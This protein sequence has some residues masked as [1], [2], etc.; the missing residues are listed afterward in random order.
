MQLTR[1][2]MLKLAATMAAGSI[3]AA[4]G[5]QTPAAPSADQPP[6]AGSAAP[7]AGAAPSAGQ[8]TAAAS[9]TA[10]AATG[11]PVKITL[12]ESWFAVPQFQESI[13]P[14][15]KALSEKMQKEGLNIELESLILDDHATKYPVLY[16]SGADF[17]MAFDAPWYKMDSLRS[18][19]ALAQLEGLIDQYGPKLKE[20]ITDKIYQ[21]NLIDGHQYGIPTVYYY[22]SSSGVMLREDLR[23]KYNAPAPTPDGGW[24]SLTPYL[25]AIKANEPGLIPFANIPS[26]SIPDIYSGHVMAPAKGM[27]IPDATKDLKLIDVEDWPEFIERAKLLRV[28]WEQDLINKTDLSLSGQSQ[29]VQADYIYPGKAAA[30]TENEPDYK[31]IDQSKQLKASIPDGA[32]MGY[33]MKGLRAGKRSFGAL[34]AGNFIVFNGNAPK[35]QHVAGIQFFNWLVGSQD[36]LDLWLMG[37]EGVNY[38]KEDNMRFSEIPGTDAARNYRRQWYVSGVSGRFQRQPVDLP[39]AAAEALTFFSTESNWDFNKYEAFQIDRKAVE[40]ELAKLEAVYTEA[41]HGIY[42]GQVATDE[43][44]Q[45]A[46]QLLDD[47]GRQELK[48]KVQQ[49]L[50]DFVAKLK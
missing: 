1:R 25:E 34:K 11:A 39:P 36:N 4:C 43:A 45:Q 42:T 49:Q 15:T 27:V 33:D 5:G 37:I 10:P 30:C 14:V 47:A 48:Q 26:Y 29:T 28:W 18:Q 2:Q 38:K 16:S 9:A 46:K 22:G 32:L 50:D 24:A 3:L 13:A 8:P 23:T 12:V 17:T 21:A 35:E 6:A 41:M 31:F 44:L 20:A 40:V 19:N 7:T